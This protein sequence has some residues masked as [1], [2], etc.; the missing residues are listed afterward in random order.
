MK[1]S[2]SAAVFATRDAVVELLRQ[3][4]AEGEGSG[5]EEWGA[6]WQLMLAARGDLLSSDDEKTLDRLLMWADNEL[7]PGSFDGL[8]VEL[9]REARFLATEIE[10]VR[11]LHVALDGV[12]A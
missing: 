2:V 7:G 3:V 4:Q 12:A 10:K 1:P 9:E 8:P 6:K 11:L 5:F